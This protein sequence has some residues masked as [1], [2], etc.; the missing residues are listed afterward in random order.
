VNALAAHADDPGDRRL[1][2][3][4]RKQLLGLLP[5]GFPG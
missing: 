2:L 4:G 5:P 3:A 1:L